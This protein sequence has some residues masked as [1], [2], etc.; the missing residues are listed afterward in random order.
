MTRL[1]KRRAWLGSH[2]T[3]TSVRLLKTTNTSSEVGVRRLGAAKAGSSTT[4][5]AGDTV[6]CWKSS[7]GGQEGSFN[8]FNSSNSSNSFNSISICSINSTFLFEDSGHKLLPQDLKTGTP[9]CC[10][11]SSA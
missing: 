10:Q 4:S 3:T 1:G 9:I 2:Q 11:R 6:A 5:Q 7:Q 8:S